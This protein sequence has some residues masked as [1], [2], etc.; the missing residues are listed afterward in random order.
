MFCYTL[1]FSPLPKGKEE[2]SKEGKGG[3]NEKR[4]KVKGKGK[5]KGKT[6]EIENLFYISLMEMCQEQCC[7]CN[8]LALKKSALGAS[9]SFPY[10]IERCLFFIV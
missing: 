3:R 9:T 7:K 2:K 10:F 6:K 4:G 1:P 8:P 5:G